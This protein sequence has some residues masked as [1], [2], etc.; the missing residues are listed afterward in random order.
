M[1]PAK[2][3]NFAHNGVINLKSNVS[4]SSFQF[5][6]KKSQTCRECN[7]EQKTCFDF[8]VVVVF[9]CFNK[10]K[11]NVFIVEIGLKP[12]RTSDNLTQSVR[13]QFNNNKLFGEFNTF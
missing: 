9:E 6:K 5:S 4:F 10:K 1:N 3:E 8:T 12:D 7:N 11:K 2:T 13:T